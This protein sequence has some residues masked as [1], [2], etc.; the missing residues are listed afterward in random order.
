[1][2]PEARNSAYFTGFLNSHKMFQKYTGLKD[3]D[4]LKF[5]TD[6]IALSITASPILN[7]QVTNDDT[8]Q[9]LS[10]RHFPHKES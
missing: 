4:F 7:K 3:V 6:N 8:I 5:L 2:I 1:M 9:R 10:G